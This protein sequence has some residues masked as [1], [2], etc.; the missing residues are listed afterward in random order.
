MRADPV[1]V[2]KRRIATL[3]PDAALRLRAAGPQIAG[4]A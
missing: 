4:I 1:P 3:L 2:M